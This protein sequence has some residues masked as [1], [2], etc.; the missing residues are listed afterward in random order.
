MNL[1]KSYEVIIVGGSYAG[2]SA[3]MALGRSLRSVL[4]IDAN[5]PCNRQTPHSHNF[6]TQDG[7]APHKIAQK[8]K[9]QV[10]KYDTVKFLDD[11]AISGKNNEK[12]FTI[13]T[14]AGKEFE[15]RKL[16]FAT[17]I[18]D[19]MPNIEGFSE[20]WGISAIHCPYCHGYEFRNEKTA[21]MANGDHAF[22]IASLV[23][24]LTNELSIYTQ[25]KP[26]FT[27]D[28]LK[29]LSNNNIDIVTDTIKTFEHSK[30]AIKR[31]LFENGTS[32]TVKAIYAALP[33]EH[34]TQLPEMLG[35]TFDEGGFI[36]TDLFQKTEIPGIYACGDNSQKMRSVSSAV[37][38]GTVS[39]AMVNY[40]LTQEDF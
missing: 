40:E 28:Q 13:R 20:C 2:L 29:K 11:T 1:S 34:H 25:G 22:H 9:E 33:F 10:L 14:I 12:G 19:L 5:K 16:I 8:A 3:A 27:D 6:I 15:G 38:S 4:I 24:N 36:K 37:A 35:C 39:G 17:G 32:Q 18:K 30:G 7:E 21:I 23:N 26:E 31:F